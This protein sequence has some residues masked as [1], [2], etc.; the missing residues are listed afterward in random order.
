MAGT[1]GSKY[2]NI[3]LKQKLQLV[4]SDDNIVISEEG[5][6]LLSEIMTCHSIVAAS[7]KMG[8][9]YRKAW[10][11]LREIEQVLGFQ[12]ILKHRGGKAG[13]KTFLTPE[14][15]ELSNAYS[16]L[17]YNADIAVHDSVKGFFR[18]INSIQAN[19]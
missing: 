8:I 6:L 17:K 18:R 19:K 14:G 16:E 2:Y 4:N 3:F 1:K 5:F 11:L 13:G 15:T 10:G 9:S 12:L 7:K